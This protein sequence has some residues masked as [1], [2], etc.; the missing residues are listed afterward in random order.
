[1]L[2]A[3]EVVCRGASVWGEEFVRV[4]HSPKQTPFEM[5]REEWAKTNVPHSRSYTLWLQIDS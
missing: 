5:G 1:M 2:W 4:S 3:P